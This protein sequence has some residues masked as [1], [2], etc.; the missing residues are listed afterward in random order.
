MQP[1]GILD[2][3][4]QIV[5]RLGAGG[6]GEVYKAVHT[7]LGSTRV[8]KVVHPQIAGS[9]DAS[10]RFLREARA[11][12]KVQHQNVA[13]LHDFSGLPDGAHYMVWEY[14]DGENLGQRLRRTGVMSPRQAI[15]VAV[16]ALHG[17]E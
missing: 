6:M 4:Y 9:T 15:R 10:D 3:K 14:I 2:N 12:T 13:T 11:A 5:E 7:Y 1:N 8:I 17:L 16:Q